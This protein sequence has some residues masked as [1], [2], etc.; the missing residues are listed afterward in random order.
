MRLEVRGLSFSY[1]A[2][3]VLRD[4]SFSCGEGEPVAVLGRNGVGKST[5]FRCLLRLLAPARGEILL[6]GRRL[7]ALRRAR[8]SS[9]LAYIPQSASPVFN[10]TVRDTVLMGT[11]GG[12]PLLAAPKQKEL[13]AVDAALAQLG[14]VQLRE[15]GVCD[16]SGGERQLVLIARAIVQRAKILIM[17][18]PTAN[19]DYGNQILVMEQIRALAAQGYLVLF[20]THNPEHALL[21]SGKSLV[22]SDGAVLAFGETEQILTQALLRQIYGIPVV[23][24][25]TAVDGKPVRLCAP[26]RTEGTQ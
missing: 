9:Y 13:D 2:R 14:I 15:R 17:D 1:G 8:L 24:L 7:S 25:E 20:S 18:E 3:Q 12:L 21:Y 5:L 10:Y 19:L 6:D 22:L 23:V 26:G 4:V 11:T 16:L